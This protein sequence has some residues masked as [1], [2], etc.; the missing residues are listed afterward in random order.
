MT[1]SVSLIST[2]EAALYFDS[3]MPLDGL[4]AAKSKNSAD[5]FSYHIPYEDHDLAEKIVSSLLIDQD[6]SEVLSYLISLQWAL[7]FS[8]TAS[9]RDVTK[10][11]VSL[12]EGL[13]Q[14]HSMSFAIEDFINGRLAKEKLR[15]ALEVYLKQKDYHTCPAWGYDPLIELPTQGSAARFETALSGLNLIDVAK[16]SWDAVIEFRKDPE[17]CRSLRDLR[18]FFDENFEG[19]S[20]SYVEDK[21]LSILD[22]QDTVARLWGFETIQKSLSVAFSNQSSIAASM[23]GLAAAVSGAPLSAVAGAALIVPFGSVAVEF[24]KVCIDAKKENI[25]RPVRFL[26]KLKRLAK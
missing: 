23:T 22:K 25:D 13:S 2:K 5:Q 7:I 12:C 16:V 26:S 15:A 11:D 14:I 21:L 19:K 17:S 24:A 9:F 18:V 1:K 8:E 10:T 20:S 6:P 3:V 4:T